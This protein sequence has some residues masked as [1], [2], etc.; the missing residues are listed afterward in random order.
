MALFV[1]ETVVV[2]MLAKMRLPR[3][4]MLDL[5]TKIGG[6]R[7]NV[8]EHEPANVIGFETWRWGTRFFREEEG[9]KELGWSLCDRD[10]V[11]GIRNSDLGIKLVCCGTDPNTGTEKS[12]K[13]LSERGSS[14]RKLIEMNSDQMKMEFV[15]DEPRDDLWYYCSYFCDKFISLEISRPIS[16]IGGF[17][18]KFSDRIVIAKPGEI[19]GIRRFTVPQE[20]ADVPKPQVFRK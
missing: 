18:T 17:I 2:P 8:R 14:S 16:E 11:A 4:T 3:H 10:Q 15:K 6:E 19:P 5:A 13:N 20:F 7:A 9:L 12:P 1:E